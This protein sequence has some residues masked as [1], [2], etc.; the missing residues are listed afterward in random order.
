VKLVPRYI[1][2]ISYSQ[3]VSVV[4]EPS[5]QVAFT[6]TIETKWVLPE[7]SSVNGTVVCEEYPGADAKHYPVDDA[8]GRNVAIQAQYLLAASAYERNPLITA[9]RLANYQYINM[10]QAMRQG[11]E[12]GKQAIEKLDLC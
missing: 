8:A 4:N 2:S 11:I 3:P 10:D 9:G 5:R 1:P 12:A 7:L 6:R